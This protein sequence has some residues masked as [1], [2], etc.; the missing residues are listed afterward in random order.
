MEHV[1]G[2]TLAQWMTDHPRPDLEQVRGIVE[3][4]A[5]GLQAFHRMEMLHQ[6]LR[7]EN[8]M[9]DT[10][11]TVKIIDFG[12]VRVAGVDER[13]GPLE[14]AGILGTLQYTAP[15]YFVGDPGSEQSD[16]YSLGVIAYQMLSGRLPYGAEAARVRSR[17]AQRRLQYDPLVDA[18]AGVPAWVDAALRKA[19]HPDPRERYASLSELLYDLRHP[20]AE[21]LRTPSLAERNPVRFWKGVSCVL[22][23]ALFLVLLA[24]FGVKA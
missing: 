11:G 9:I 4:I 23:L 21:L 5:R 13:A 17:A 1:E 15:E 24:K 7:P 8:I 2:R 10:T 3:Q 16:L 6:D 14:R 20:N 22:G 19:V 12:S 18:E